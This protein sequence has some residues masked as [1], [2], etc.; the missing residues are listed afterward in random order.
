LRGKGEG[1]EGEGREGERGGKGQDK[2]DAYQNQKLTD[3]AVVS[4]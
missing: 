4:D 1:G 2:E 3:T